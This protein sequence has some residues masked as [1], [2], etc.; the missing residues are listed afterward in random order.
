MS[1]PYGP[2]PYAERSSDPYEAYVQSSPYGVPMVRQHPKSTPILVLGLLSI[3]GLSICGPIAW[4]MGNNAMREIDASPAQYTDRGTVNVGRILGIIGTV[5]L[6]LT[7]LGFG[8]LIVTSV[9]LA[10]TGY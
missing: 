3:L 10:S 4:V 1:N 6:I 2:D 7:V 5:L 8:F 9:V